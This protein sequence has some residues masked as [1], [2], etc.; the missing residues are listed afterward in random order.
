MTRVPPLDELIEA[1]CCFRLPSTQFFP[2][3]RDTCG[4][5]SY[6]IHENASAGSILPFAATTEKNKKD[7]KVEEEQLQARKA[8]LRWKE[9]VL[10]EGICLCRS[11][12]CL[13]QSISIGHHL[14]PSLHRTAT[15]DEDHFWVM[16]ETMK[17]GKLKAC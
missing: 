5:L 10:K 4:V 9:H 3:Y 6:S 13:I 8:E 12:H 1:V 2:V 7:V 14:F 17:K 11:Q 16:S 15:T